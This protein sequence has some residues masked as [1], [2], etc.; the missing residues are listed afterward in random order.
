VS[1]RLEEVVPWGRTIAEYEAMF[2]LDPTALSGSILGCG[3]GPASFNAEAT[4]RGINV[5]SVDPLYRFDEVSIRRR[6]AEVFDTVVGQTRDNHDEF[7]WGELIRDV[8]H[9]AEIRRN[10]MD[11][12]LADFTTGKAAGRYVEGAL[13]HLDFAQESFDL[14]LC[15]HYLFLYSEQVSLADHVASILEMRR[16]AKEVRVFPLQELGSRP[17]RHL[18]EIVRMLTAAGHQI[19]QR[20]V[21]YEFQRGGN[22]VLVIN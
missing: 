19:E 3:D 5:V 8:E 7:V 21:D 2:A 16:V 1:Y 15:S 4:Q 14:A 10:A 12:F 22:Q 6:I 17:S 9:L 11:R 13:P 20:Q 18:E